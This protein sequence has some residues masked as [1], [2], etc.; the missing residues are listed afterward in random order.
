MRRE[1]LIGLL[2]RIDNMSLFTA[3]EDRRISSIQLAINQ[4]LDAFHIL[5]AGHPREKHP[6]SSLAGLINTTALIHYKTG[7]LEWARQLIDLFLNSMLIDGSATLASD[8]KRSILQPFI[9]RGRLASHLGDTGQALATFKEAYEYSSGRGSLRLGE[10]TLNPD[11]NDVTQHPQ[12][13]ATNAFVLDSVRACLI[14]QDF[15]ALETVVAS[16]DAIE[17]LGY[18]YRFVQEGSIRLLMYQNK[19]DQASARIST[20][21]QAIKHDTIPDP[22]ILVLL[23]SVHELAGQEKEA[24][25]TIGVLLRYAEQLAARED[26]RDAYLR[27][28]YHLAKVLLRRNADEAATSLISQARMV[29]HSSGDCAM[30]ARLV[31]IS[32][33][34]DS[35]RER[36]RAELRSES[37]LGSTIFGAVDSL[38]LHRAYMILESA[39][40]LPVPGVD[41][42]PVDLAPYYSSLLGIPL[43]K[44]SPAET[45]GCRLLAESRLHRLISTCLSTAV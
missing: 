1:A 38:L 12:H 17:N 34:C 41:G 4:N 26:A 5:T 2:D 35:G 29:A 22:S 9:N 30:W 19:W 33:I 39:S 8:S 36:T 16:A 13:V 15:T 11:S 18:A 40:P 10:F 28:S 44:L 6:T 24:G 3:R 42:E 27:L 7:N 45:I 14:A 20:L 23:V 43:A 25:L 37:G 21:W 32:A 31:C